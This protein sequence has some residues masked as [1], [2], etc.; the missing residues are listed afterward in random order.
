MAFRSPAGSRARVTID[1]LADVQAIASQAAGEVL[2]QLAPQA[3]VLVENR[4]LVNGGVKTGH[5]AAQNPACG[6]AP[7][8]MARA[9][10]T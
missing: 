7:R 6:V 9:L 10:I 8:A 5:V 1:G 2:I 4:T 3:A